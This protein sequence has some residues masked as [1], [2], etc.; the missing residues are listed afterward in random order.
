[1]GLNCNHTARFETHFKKAD[2]CW[3]WGASRIRDGY[4]RFHAEGQHY[5]AHRASYELYVG[6]IPADKIVLHSC[7]NP[8]CVNPAHLKLGTYAD[9]MADKV[10][11]GRESHKGG[12]NFGESNGNSKLGDAQRVQLLALW[13]TGDYTRG[14]LAKQFSLSYSW[15]SRIVK[16][17]AK[18]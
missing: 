9:N 13:V 14:E 2:G 16:G 17:V 1:M 7:D 18:L 11:K 4:G 12:S 6:C 8:G 3:E 5:V 15:V 10:A